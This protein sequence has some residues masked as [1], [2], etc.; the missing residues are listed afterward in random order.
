MSLFVNR[1]INTNQ[2]QI[3]E[4]LGSYFESTFSSINYTPSFISYKNSILSL[5]LP[6]DP[7]DHLEINKPFQ[8]SEIILALSKAKGSSPGHDEIHYEMLKR[9]SENQKYIILDFYNEIWTQHI[10]PNSWRH[11]FIV[12]ILK[13][14]TDQKLSKRATGQS[15][16]LVVYQ[17]QCNVWCHQD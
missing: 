6:P 17:R 10:Y 16:C 9:L 8:I 11:C 14:N 15:V 3:L 4:E 2:T 5:T 12:P 13:P 1:E 7:Y